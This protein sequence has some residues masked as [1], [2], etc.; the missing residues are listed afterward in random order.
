M[1]RPCSY[2]VQYFPFDAGFFRDKKVRKLRAEFGSKG[3]EAYV[4]LLCVI[5]EEKGYFTVWDDDARLF[6]AA[7]M[8]YTPDFVRELTLGC[9]KC[10]L[11]D[12]R[13]FNV[14]QVLTSRGIQRR[15]LQMV[16][17]RGQIVLEK[18]LLL[19]DLND[20][21]NVPAGVRGKICLRNSFRQENPGFCQE[22]PGFCQEN[23]VKESKVNKSKVK[24]R[25]D[26]PPG[27]FAA[28]TRSE[29][30]AYC[31]Q[32]Q[33]G[34]NPDRFFDYYEANGWK[35]GRNPMKDWKAAVRA[36]E[37]NGIDRAADQPPPSYD[38][39]GIMQAAMDFDP[40]KT[41]RGEV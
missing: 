36:W 26:K 6:F 23:P 12:E 9:V 13:V 3:F 20:T 29:V 8:G 7:D 31:Q 10:G 18:D 24:E 39:D 2:G 22:N 19:V 15:Y 14:F 41:K 17:N 5:Y 38:L 25:E 30:R 37:K 34:I 1:A 27:R 4:G 35:V 16:R 28:P 32:R 21:E 33:N 40:T 11:F